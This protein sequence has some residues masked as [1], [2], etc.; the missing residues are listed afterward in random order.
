MPVQRIDYCR[1]LDHLA[2]TDRR[3]VLNRDLLLALA[4][5]PIQCR[6]WS[7]QRT[8]ISI[9]CPSARSSCTF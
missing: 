8:L 9:R 6:Q 5:V 2:G 1:L 4:A 3:D 7:F